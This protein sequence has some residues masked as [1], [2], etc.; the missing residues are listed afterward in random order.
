MTILG[1]DQCPKSI[2]DNVATEMCGLVR[3]LVQRKLDVILVRKTTA[4]KSKHAF[5]FKVLTTL[6]MLIATHSFKRKVRQ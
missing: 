3:N 1:I 2:E 4:Q 5:V 6:N